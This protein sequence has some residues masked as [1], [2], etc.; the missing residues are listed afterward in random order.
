M[1]VKTIILR[2][3]GVRKEAFAAAAI[4]PGDLI[5]RIAAGTVQRHAGAGLTAA[6]L[7][8]VENEVVGLNI[9]ADYSALDTVL[10][11]AFP[12]GTEIFTQVAANAAAIVIGDVLES[13]GAGGLRIQ[14]TD[15]A[16][17]DTQR[18]SAVAVALEA[19]NNAAVGVRARIKVE[20]L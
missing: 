9:D 13:D 15:P 3:S 10:F 4:T 17:D 16:T 6:P 20:L 11:G 5:E 18:R 14:I 12:P 2:G 8:A 1:T 19:L 7:F